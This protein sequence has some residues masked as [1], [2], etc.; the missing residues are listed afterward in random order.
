MHNFRVGYSC[1]ML[2]SAL[3]T[4]RIASAQDAAP[5][6]NPSQGSVIVG[7]AA[8]ATSAERRAEANNPAAGPTRF[9]RMR[10][11]KKQ[12]LSLDTAV[13]SYSSSQPDGVT[14]DLIAAVHIAEGSYY[15]QLN[16][17][18]D[19]YD[20]LLYELVAPE[21]TVIPV[22][23]RGEQRGFNPV[24]ML[25]DSAK[26]ML[27]LESQLE[28]V[29]YTKSHFVRADLTPT[30]ISEKMAERG[31]TVL[32]LALSTFADVLRQ[33]ELASREPGEAN[34]ASPADVSLYD[35]F[36]NPLKMKRVLAQEFARTGSLDQ[37]LG[38]RL[39]Q[40]LIVDRNA[41]A[42]KSLQKQIAAGKKKIGIFYGAAH[43]P[44]FELHLVDDFGL[45]KSAEKW[46]VAWD[47][48]QAKQ[49]ELSQPA[50]LLLNL[51]KELE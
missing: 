40:L 12:P 48:Q 31:E 11:E 17:L 44:D 15:D 7:E 42:L 41:A 37:A 20:V 28:R 1:V 39:S 26:N 50:S 43:L 33:Q 4:V 18:F 32:T 29:D 5:E 22:G 10:V 6:L 45:H 3:G 35:M 36:G 19:S 51:L 8:E 49:P 13:V 46:L 14:V 9:L 38:E 24:G 23:G 21:G 30:Q 2:L 16:E 25:Q 47:L 27:G 34:I